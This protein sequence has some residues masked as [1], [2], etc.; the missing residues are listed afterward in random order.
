MEREV[1]HVAR[2]DTMA[3]ARAVEALYRG[4]IERELWEE[5]GLSG[6]KI[7]PFPLSGSIADAVEHIRTQ[8]PAR[9]ERL[10]AADARLPR[11]TCRLPAP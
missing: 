9:I 8:D 1:V 2:I 4:E 10:L 6:R 11:R 3:L 7:D 5:R